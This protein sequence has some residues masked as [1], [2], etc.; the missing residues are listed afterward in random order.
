MPLRSLSDVNA[1]HDDGRWHVQRVLKNAGVS[2][3]NWADA[4]FASGQPAYDARVGVAGRFTPC[5]AQGNDAVFFPPVPFGMERKLV[6]IDARVAQSAYRGPVSLYLFDLVGYYPM[7]DGDST[8]EQLMDNTLPLPRYTGGEGVHAVIVNHIAPA[9]QS[10]VAV[11]NYTDSKGVDRTATI[12]VANNGV[13]LVCSGVRPSASAD[14]GPVSLSLASGTS[15]IRKINSITYSTPPSG[16]HAIYLIKP[17]ATMTLGDN[18]VVGEKQFFIQNG[19][20]MPL[21]PD[22]AWLSWFDRIAG[23]TATTTTFFGQFTFAWG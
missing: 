19:T 1:A 18:G 7:I 11:L 13:G 12:G 6:A 9:Q 5:V 20:S 8:D 14:M 3:I 22:G 15:G 17:F 21:I 23:S 2:H 4:T 10:G 16:L